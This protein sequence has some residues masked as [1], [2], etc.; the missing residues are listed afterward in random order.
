MVWPAPPRPFRRARVFVRASLARKY[1]GHPSVLL[2]LK[3]FALN[4]ALMVTGVFGQVVSGD[5]LSG[6]WQYWLDAAFGP[7]PLVTT[8]N[9]PLT[10]GMSLGYVV[11]LDL[12]YWIAHWLMHR[13][14]VMWEFHKLHHSAQVLTPLTEWRQHPVELFLFPIC[15]TLALGTFYG[16]AG[17]IFGADAQPLTWLQLNVVLL[18]F[19]ATTLHLRHSHLWLPTTGW[20]GYVIQSPAHHQIHLSEREEH[21]DKNLGLVLSIWDWAFG[22][23]HIPSRQETLTFGIGAEGH[24]HDGALSAY[25]APM[26]KAFGHVAPAPGAQPVN[27]V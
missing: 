25:W 3:L 17:Y 1:L 12:G 9:W 21:F 2:D 4:S 14:P 18:A 15:I 16:V 19:M 22:T 8:A 13:F 26:R 27:P 6:T 11:F 7:S 5:K 10:L 23:L 20:L 24:E